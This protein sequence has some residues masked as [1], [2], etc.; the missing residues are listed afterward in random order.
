MQMLGR[1]GDEG[2]SAAR[3]EARRPAPPA[4]NRANTPAYEDFGDP[5]FNPDDEIPF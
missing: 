5:P 4:A 2:G 1:P 3:G